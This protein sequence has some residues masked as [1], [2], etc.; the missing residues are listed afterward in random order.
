MKA[1][2]AFI[3]GV[4]IATSWAGDLLVDQVPV[5]VLT[6]TNMHPV[7][8]T[9]TTV[10]AA[11]AADRWEKFEAEFGIQHP[12]LSAMKSSLQTAKYQLDRT[13]LA[14][15]EFVDTVTDWLRFDYSLSDA[16][17][18]T[19]SRVATGNFVTDS[20]SQV[21]LKSDIDLKLGEKVFVGVKL[22]LPLGN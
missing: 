19:R 6:G 5:A 1:I 8:V 4:G 7:I 22:V 17:L 16:G 13:T 10:A 18:A 2:L 15:Q 21:R 11:P 3:A 9:T 20:L 14:M 12:S